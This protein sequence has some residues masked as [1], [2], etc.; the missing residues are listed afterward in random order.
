[1]C[2]DGGIYDSLRTVGRF[3]IRIIGNAEWGL[4]RGSA[5]AESSA[6]DGPVMSPYNVTCGHGVVAGAATSMFLFLPVGCGC[7]DASRHL[8]LSINGR[9]KLDLI[10]S[11]V[12]GMGFRITTWNGKLAL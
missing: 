4:A 12:A 2:S 7:W 3:G 10:R 1:M 5:T 9:R 6:T 8:L 11:A